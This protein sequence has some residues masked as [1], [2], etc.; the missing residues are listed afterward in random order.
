MRSDDLN[1]LL[2]EGLVDNLL[3]LRQ[4][5]PHSDLGCPL[6]QRRNNSL[7]I[8]IVI[9]V[10]AIIAQHAEGVSAGTMWLRLSARAL[11]GFNKIELVDPMRD[12]S[13]LKD[14]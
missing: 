9:I 5:R 7:L 13:P 1:A 8:I 10:L 3:A 14:L 6:L 4:F 11:V 12:Y 2:G